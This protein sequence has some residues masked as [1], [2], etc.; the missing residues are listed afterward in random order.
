[1]TAFIII[2]GYK[3]PKTYYV[4]G[5]F[6]IPNI[7]RKQGKPI[8]VHV[9]EAQIQPV[10]WQIVADGKTSARDIVNIVVPNSSRIKKVFVDI[11]SRVKQGDLLIELDDYVAKDNFEDAKARLKLAEKSLE[12]ALAGERVE[13]A[14]KIVLASKKAKEKMDMAGIR[15][16]QDKR[17][18]AAGVIPG[19]DLESSE[20][21]YMER[22]IEYLSSIKDI[23]TSKSA[24]TEDIDKFKATFESAGVSYN[25]ALKN[26]RLIRLTAPL[27]GVVTFKDVFAGEI[28]DLSSGKLLTVCGKMLFEA[29]VDQMY[30]DWIQLNQKVDISLESFPGTIFKGVVKHRHAI[31]S[32]FS[33]AAAR[34]TFS[35]W[36]EFENSRNLMFGLPGY[37]RIF[38]NRD[39]LV[40]PFS[41]LF[42]YSGGEGIVFV[43]GKEN[44]VELRPVSYRVTPD[45]NAE[46]LTNLKQGEQVVTTYVRALKNGD[47]VKRVEDKVSG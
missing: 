26:L 8:P 35:V 1:M 28:K 41:S 7:L 39:A 10:R 5:A 33:N 11:G 40:V 19:I 38:A 36:I 13:L 30:V 16:D 29:A 20:Q 14:E 17:L 15:L 25:V 3:S 4:N 44:Q 31:L 32:T 46:I 34:P 42:H 23:D 9:A 45:G 21:E 6:G 43:V 37:A 2:P 22:K 47:T 27:D 24:R 18:F 12:I